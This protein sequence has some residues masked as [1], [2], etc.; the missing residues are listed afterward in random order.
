MRVLVTGGAGYIGSHAA[1]ALREAGHDVLILDSFIRGNRS[2]IQGFDCL[3]ADIGDAEA[4]SKALRG[5]NAVMH[6]AAFAYVGESVSSPRMYFE[7]NVQKAI[8]L[9]NAAVDAGLQFFVFSSTCAVYGIPELIPVAESAAKKPVNPYG[10]TKLYFESVLEEYGRAYGLKHI[11]LRYF[12]AAGADPLGRVGEIHNPETH[13][14]P[15]IFEVIAGKR[16]YVEIY[17][18]DYPTPDGTCVRDYTHVT[19]LAAAHVRALDLLQDGRSE[20]TAVNLGT[21]TGASIREVI[22]SVEKITGESVTTRISPRRAGDPPE[23]VAD[24]TLANRKLG[25]K[26]RYDLDSMIE[27]AWAWTQQHNP[28]FSR[29][30]AAAR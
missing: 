26:A 16:P 3:E 18:D 29:I 19:D 8:T 9:V 14:I 11:S 17:G 2:L 30:R 7:N 6:F 1:V 25:W 21:G 22:K 4:V 20:T 10:M 15:T 12:N 27:T 24:P 13:L 5:V 28:T 23:L